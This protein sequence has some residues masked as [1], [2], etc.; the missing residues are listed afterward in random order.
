MAP[1]CCYVNLETSLACRMIPTFGDMQTIFLGMLTDSSVINTVLVS[2][3][4]LRAKELALKKYPPFSH[5]VSFVADSFPKCR[6]DPS[7]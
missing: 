7:C 2:C 4:N 3:F 5:F 1:L 6:P